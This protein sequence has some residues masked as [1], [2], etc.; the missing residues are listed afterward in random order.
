L[1]VIWMPGFFYAVKQTQTTMDLPVHRRLLTFLWTWLSFPFLLIFEGVMAIL[2]EKMD[3]SN[4]FVDYEA[5]FEDRRKF[6]IVFES[7]LQAG[8]SL[9]VLL[10]VDALSTYLLL[11][12]NQSGDS[13]PVGLPLINI[14]SLICSVLT[15]SIG[16]LDTFHKNASLYD[17]ASFNLPNG[18][19]L[20][21]Y[22]VELIVLYESLIYDISTLLLEN[23]TFATLDNRF[24]VVV[25]LI[26]LVQF[27]FNYIVVLTIPGLCANISWTALTQENFVKTSTFCVKVFV[28]CFTLPSNIMNNY[29]LHKLFDFSVI[30]TIFF[31]A[32]GLD[33][34]HNLY[35][36]KWDKKKWFKVLVTLGI[37]CCLGS[38]GATLVIV[39]IN[40]EARIYQYLLVA[41]IC[42]GLMAGLLV[43]TKRYRESDGIIGLVLGVVTAGTLCYL[44][45]LFY[46]SY[47]EFTRPNIIRNFTNIEPTS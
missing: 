4:V 16:I 14:I 42:S 15:L 3:C 29:Y 2:P 34:V 31:V 12:D 13:S 11:L 21:V 27:P 18:G 46:E 24:A 32:L 47:E 9:Y 1:A 37:V 39:L 19:V 23:G 43:L 5:Q 38:V 45:G 35:Q 25:V 40:Y 28:L 30:Q 20:L 17:R 10:K 41:A 6:E 8:I 22:I 7:T 33:I 36:L 44:A 26:L